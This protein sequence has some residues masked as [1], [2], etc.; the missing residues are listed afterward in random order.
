MFCTYNPKWYYVETIEKSKQKEIKT[1]LDKYLQQDSTYEVPEDWGCD[2]LST[3]NITDPNIPWDTFLKNTRDCLVNF[4]QGCGI[5]EQPDVLIS[6]LWA[7]KYNHGMYQGMH[8]HSH[9][10][11]NLVGVYFYQQP[12][13]SGTFTFYDEGHCHYES[14]GLESILTLPS[15]DLHAPKV[16]E[17]SVIL[18]APNTLH[19]VTKHKNTLESKISIS[20]NLN[21]VPLKT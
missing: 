18:F 13:D 15:T 4:I 10:T 14:S 20:F 7:N 19:Y 1:S 17:G 12:K 21:L 16:K 9:R 5:K 11:C 6:G 2:V 3:C 8:Q